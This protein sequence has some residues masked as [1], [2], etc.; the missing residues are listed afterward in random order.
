MRIK[1]IRAYIID[2]LILTLI[3]F[4]INTFLPLD[5]KT[6]DLQEDKRSIASSYYKGTL[7]YGEYIE[8]YGRINYEI[9]KNMVINNITYL[10]F[11]II[12]F[13]VVP[14]LYHGRTIGARLNNI[15]IESFSDSNLKF[16]QIIIRALLITG[17][18]YVF[19]KNMLVFI[20]NENT[21][22]IGI[23][24]F[25]LIQVIILGISLFMMIREKD[26]RGLH[27]ILSNTE[28]VKITE[29]R[30]KNNK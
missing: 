15:Q 3:L 9:D 14:I 12:Y 30:M 24:I 20:L 5:K 10:V 8:V 22:F 13:I 23:T 26:K 7:T 19:M 21:Y 4:I 16:Y 2:F 25:S 29:K 1:R 11:M 27:E 28:M 6:N 18:G 17:L